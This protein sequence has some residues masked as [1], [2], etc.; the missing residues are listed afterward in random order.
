MA[1]TIPGNGRVSTRIA[2][3]CID[4][5]LSKSLVIYILFF[6]EAGKSKMFMLNPAGNM[7][8]GVKTNLAS[9]PTFESI[10]GDF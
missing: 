5:S 4:S 3:F 8:S 9:I 2:D 10:G 1:E 7:A 6:M